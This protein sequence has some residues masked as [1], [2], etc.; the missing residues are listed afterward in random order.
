MAVAWPIHRKVRF[1]GSSDLKNWS[2]LSDFGPAGSTTGIW[3]CPDL[4]PIA[5]SGRGRTDKWLLVV[6]VGSGAPAGG[7]GCQYFTGRFDGTHF[8]P[9]PQPQGAQWADWGRDFYAAVSWSDI[10]K[11]DGRR[12]WLG[13]MSNWDYANDVPTSPWRSAMSIPRSLRLRDSEQGL[14]LL[15]EPVDE[16][17]KLRH[18]RQRIALKEVS[19]IADLGALADRTSDT[20]ELEAELELEKSSGLA[21]RIAGKDTEETVLRVDTSVGEARLDRTRSGE[22]GFHK[23]FPG[24]FRSPVRT[25]DGKLKIRM[26]VDTSSV[27]IFFNEGETVITGLVLMKPGQRK[28]GLEVVRGK[29]LEGRVSTWDLRSAWRGGKVAS[30]EP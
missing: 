25:I 30:R 17:K 14:R 28:L 3:E 1:Y 22:V 20:F 18:H 19:A 6:N 11:R 16:L 12:I 13:W 9:D 27:E 24:V 15:Q 2:H 26:F 8:H 10:P 21:L 4:F 29:V 7:S 5:L 23:A